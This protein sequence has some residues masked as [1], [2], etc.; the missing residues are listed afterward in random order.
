MHRVSPALKSKL[1]KVAYWIAGF[2]QVTRP[3]PVLE[4]HI[5]GRAYPCAFALVS[6]VRH[7][8]GDFE[9]ARNVSLVDDTFEVALFEGTQ[10]RHFVKYLLG[11]MLGRLEGMY[12]V[13]Y[14]RAE[15]VTL[16]GPR[17]TPV[18]VQTDGEY[19]GTLPATV[20]VVPEALTLLMPARYLAARVAQIHRAVPA[21]L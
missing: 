9:I 16:T 12:G 14:L 19:A 7:Y 6:R 18:H 17:E 2:G 20:D 15:R 11:M 10:G 3:L 5:D 13:T 8:G 4:A 21:P 1:G